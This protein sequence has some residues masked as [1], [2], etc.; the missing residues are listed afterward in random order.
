MKVIVKVIIVLML[1]VALG[2]FAFTA[3]IHEACLKGD[4]VKVKKILEKDPGL[5]NSKGNSE[6]APIHYAV[7]GG[8][9]KLVK[10]LLNKGTPVDILNVAGQTPLAYAA[11]MGHE[12]L[13]KLL[14]ARGADLNAKTKRGIKPINYAIQ[15]NHVKVAKR[16]IK[17]GADVKGK[18]ENGWTML[19]S[20]AWSGKKDILDLLVK[21][22][23]PVDSATTN[24]RTPLHNA[25][26]YGN[27][28]GVI[29]FLDKGAKVNVIDTLGQTPL[30]KA[31]NQGRKK[32]VP[33]FLKSGA[34]VDIQDKVEKRTA[35]HYAAIK[36][37]VDIT[38]KL[39]EKGASPNLQDNSGKTPIYY[40]LKYGHKK[41]AKQI[42]KKGGK[43]DFEKTKFLGAKLLKKELK[44]GTAVVW[45]SGH[46]GWFVKTRNHL[47][48]FDYEKGSVLP[49]QPSIANGFFNPEELKDLK[50]TVFVSHAH[51]DHYKA[52]IFDW[53][54]GVKD[55]TYVT[56]FKPEG[57]DGYIFM[58]PREKKA[59]N[60]MKVIA[61]ESN[62]S[63]AGFFILVDG[64]KIFHPGDHTNRKQDF[65]GTFKKEIDFL[66]DKG[67]KVDICF[68]PVSGCGFGDLTAVKKGVFYTI[69]RLSARSVFPMHAGNNSE[70]YRKFAETAQKAGYDVPMCCA[71][72]FGDW[73][74]VHPK[75]VKGAYASKK[76]CNKKASG[77]SS[78]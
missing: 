38:T 76:T 34:R 58:G 65:S 62:D 71:E 43:F 55:I 1:M 21:N 61:I 35:L 44:E 42:L 68:A 13:A 7:Q 18:E 24:G 9:L 4:L 36:G 3:E 52:N 39:L 78:N 15:R 31:A 77:C 23:I 28:E 2:D 19:H 51:G 50:V 32:I 48:V 26:T 14:L 67:L 40:A 73:F 47:L 20:A 5:L 25:S 8:H 66:A 74:V 69:D 64:L 12:S 72:N 59:I 22:G 70:N 10:F 46:S 63:G 57:K 41:L 53:K 27:L 16:L 30:I 45:Y 49:D 37:F 75:G 56:G 60:G 54:T 11:A 6:K 29:Y 17:K 33:I